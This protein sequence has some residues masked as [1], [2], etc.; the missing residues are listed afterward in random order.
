MACRWRCGFRCRRGFGAERRRLC[1]DCRRQEDGH[2]Q[3]Q[4]SDRNERSTIHQTLHFTGLLTRLFP[5]MS[6]QQIFH[7]F[8][9]SELQNL[10]IGLHPAVERHAHLPGARKDLGIL[11]CHLVIERIGAPRREALDHVQCI[12][13][14]VSGAIEPAQVVESLR[15]DD[16]RLPF[17]AS[18]RPSHPAVSRCFR[19]IGHVD[20]PHRTRILVNEHD[21]LL[22]LDDLKRVRHVG[23][24]RHP[25][26][27]A[28]HLRIELQPVRAILVSLLERLRRIRQRPA[29]DDTE[30]SRHRAR[31]PEFQRPDW[32]QPSAPR[33]RSWRC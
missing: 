9:A 7:E 28:L 1:G 14:K 2:S 30:T 17:P 20:R 25:G 32:A 26:Q 11:D 8:D 15:V 18:V 23:G 4:G 16:Q 29:F 3:D 22:A 10:R 21:V 27:I 19:L 12:A 6:V 31:R 5:Q 33:C 24:A 13:V